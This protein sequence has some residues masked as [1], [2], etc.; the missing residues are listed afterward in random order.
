MGR[1][2]QLIE[3]SHDWMTHA[4]NYEYAYHF[5]W[6]G[7]PIIQF[8]QDMIAIQEIIWETKPDIVVE[9]GIARGGS[10]ILSASLLELLGGG[11]KVIGIDID[12][13]RHNRTDIENHP[14]SKHITLIEGSSID[15][16]IAKKV[17]KS[18][19]GKKTV[20]IL[21][22][23]HTHKHVLKELELYSPL[24]GKDSYII[25]MDTFIENMPKGFFNRPWDKGN[26]PATAVDA[27]LEKNK[28]FQRDNI[29]DK[30]LLITQS[31]GG[32]LK[33]VSDEEE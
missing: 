13:R 6:L 28:R 3:K 12:I 18:C 10:L 4:W 25:A 23:N 29:I 32:F 5:K 24:V 1:D 20:V 27:F 16:T 30:K 15:E 19:S 21:D 11:R 8:P 31:K 22:S 9:T 33:C 26:S 17:S 7:M 2:A 14:L